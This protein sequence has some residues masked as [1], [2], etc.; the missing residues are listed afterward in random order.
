LIWHRNRKKEE[1][2]K[3]ENLSEARRLEL[4]SDYDVLCKCEKQRNGEDEPRIALWFHKAS[5]Q[6]LGA[7][8]VAPR[9]YVHYS[10]AEQPSDDLAGIDSEVF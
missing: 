2:L 3:N 6:F 7:P 5:H 8:G 9:K 4:Q 1:E 10:T